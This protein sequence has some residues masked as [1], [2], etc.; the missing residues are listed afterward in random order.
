MNEG[1]LEGGTRRGSLPAGPAVGTAGPA[2]RGVV[3]S[4]RANCRRKAPRRA[5]AVG[6]RTGAGSFVTARVGVTARRVGSR[7]RRRAV[8]VLGFLDVGAVALRGGGRRHL[9]GQEVRAQLAHRLQVVIAPVLYRTL[10]SL[11][12]KPRGSRFWIQ[13]T[14]GRPV[15][16]SELAERDVE[17]VTIEVS[18]RSLDPATPFFLRLLGIFCAL[19]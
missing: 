16:L 18:R 4:R 7:T 3:R 10:R 9:P 14:P 17:S 11:G 19:R 12:E 6:G 1:E 5:R 2:G 8:V 13:L 15:F